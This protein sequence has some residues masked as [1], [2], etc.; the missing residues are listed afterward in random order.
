MKKKLNILTLSYLLF[1]VLL[2]LSGAFVGLLSDLVYFLA[3]LLPIA[4]CI[5][6]VRNEENKLKDCLYISRDDAMLFIPLIFPIISLMM[7]ISFITSFVIFNFTGK[8]YSIDLGDSYV[9]ALINHALLPAIL[10]EALF[11]YLPM[12]MI[13]PHSP[14]CA[15]IISSLFF[16]LVHGNLFQIPYAFIGGIIFMSLNLATGSII[17]SL[18]I[19]FVNN[20]MSISMSF[21]Q[22]PLVL[23]LVYV[24]IG[25]A[26]VISLSVAWRYR[27]DYEIPFLFISD[28]GEGVVFTWQMVA[29]TVM[30][31]SLAIISIL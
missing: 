24:F 31:L 30:A 16:A 4:I 28:K 11:R 22:I 2:F 29:F 15:I 27:E 3:F 7:L 19:H 1:L 8:T 23:F 5:Y 18:V 17:P 25:A 14:R 10:E 21:I 20:A 26:T 12:R 13:A 9:M 6:K